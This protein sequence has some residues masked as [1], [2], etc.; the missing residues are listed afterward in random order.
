MKERS[1]YVLT[2]PF[3]SP[4]YKIECHERAEI[5][6][7]LVH[8]IQKRGHSNWLEASHNAFI[9]FRPKYINLDRLHYVVS[10][11]LALL[12]SNMT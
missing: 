7:Q 6:K 10:T 11:E 5:S 3:H 9:R 4:A 2:C 12:Q 8:T 1:R